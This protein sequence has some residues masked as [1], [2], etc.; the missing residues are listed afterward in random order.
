MLWT[1]RI[2][3]ELLAA[4]F[5]QED[6]PSVNDLLL[7][8]YRIAFGFQSFKAGVL[9]HVQYQVLQT[10]FPYHF[11]NLSLAFPFLSQVQIS[12]VLSFRLMLQARLP[13]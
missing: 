12:I 7:F 3:V 6:R 8:S 11:L 1:I 5:D 4:L 13:S 9:S 10:T 2:Q